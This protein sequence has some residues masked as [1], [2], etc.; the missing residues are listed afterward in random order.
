MR[1]ISLIIC[2][3]SIIYLQ[4]TIDAFSFKK[5]YQYVIPPKLHEEIV[6]EEYPTQ[7][8]SKCTLKNKQGN[9]R[10]KTDKQDKIFL[11]AIKK[12]ADPQTVNKLTFSHKTVGQE[13]V[14]QSSYDELTLDGMIDFEL[15]VPQ[16]L[17]LNLATN[18]G[19]INTKDTYAPL[20]ASTQKGS[21]EAAQVYHT[22]DAHTDIKG[23]IFIRNPHKQ[24]KAHT[25][26]GNIYI[27]DAQ[28]SII[29]HAD[30]GTVQMFAKEVPST[31][32]I[33]LTTISGTILLHIPAD[34]NA[35]LQA[36]TKYGTITSDHFITLKPQT[37]QLNKQAWKRFQK[38]IDGVL[39]SG[40]AQ[41]KLSS[42]KSNIK[43]LEMK[44]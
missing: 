4:N 13:L 36:S 43:L 35:D 39:G 44:A 29:A 28:E 18:E 21:I 19:T 38:Q 7:K 31:S 10:V 1:R 15:I 14:I 5:M 30:Y 32:S 3:F 17:A 23:D 41:I 33:K 2:I 9:I 26:N 11:K 42:V 6:Y 34:V 37:T 22:L 16:K 8:L 40:E 20:A 24:V 27:Y 12:S 25:T